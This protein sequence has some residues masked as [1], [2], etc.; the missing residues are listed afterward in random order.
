M[1]PKLLA[2]IGLA[3]AAVAVVWGTPLA[4]TLLVYSI[5]RVL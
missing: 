2:A 5:T 4:V 1:R 3:L